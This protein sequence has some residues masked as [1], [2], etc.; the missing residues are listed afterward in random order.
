MSR[1]TDFIRLVNRMRKVQKL[2]FKTRTQSA[3]EDSKKLE[4]EVD[5]MLEEFG[6]EVKRVEQLRLDAT[7]QKEN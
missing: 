2:Y 6:F 7:G 1:T 4:R 3:L 5:D